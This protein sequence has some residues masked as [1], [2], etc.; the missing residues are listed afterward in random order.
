MSNRLFITPNKLHVL[1]VS[2]FRWL[3]HYAIRHPRQVLALAAVITLV[4]AP[5][6]L[7][8][9]LRTDGHA[10]V[11]PAAPEVIADKAVR[12][13]FGIHDQLVVL[14]RPGNTHGI[15][16]P[17]TLQLV[18]DLTAE[19]KQ[20]P[21]VAP[22]DVM[23][24]ATEPGFRMRPGTFL[25]QKMLE[26]PLKTQS[27][28]D[29]LREDLRRIELYNSTLVSADG[30]F[31]VILVGVPAAADRAQ[32]YAK[33]LQIITAKKTAADEIAVT[34]A[35][36]AESLFGVQI[37]EDLGVPKALLGAGAREAGEKSEWKMPSSLHE[38]RVF[39]ARHIGLVPLAA[40]VM[41]LVLLLCFRNV[42]AAL[43][44]LPGVVATMLLVFG[45]MGWLGVPIY[46]TTAVMPVL[47]TVIS[48]TNDIYLFSRYFNL[49]REKPGVNHV[50][51]VG[52]TFDK[53]TR[54]V[55]CTSLAAV[56]G[57]LSFGFSPLVPVRMFGLFTGMGALL[58]LLLSLTVVPAML[59]LT[60]PAWLRPRHRQGENTP[61]AWLA[62]KFAGAGQAVVRR[63][64]WVVGFALAV[65]ALTPLGLRQ[66]V[67]QDSWTNGFD[68][69]SEFRRVTQLVNENFFGMHLLFICAEAPRTIQ[70]EIA[71]ASF[72]GPDIA[73][74]AAL[75]GDA[76]LILGSPIK[77]SAGE[78]GGT[79]PAIWQSHIEIVN[80]SHDTVYARL[81]RTG[82]AT[83][84]P[85]ALAKAGRA[86][87]EIPVRSHFEPELI[88]ALGDFG[89]FIREH[90]QDAV[91]GVL[92]P[93]DY[94]ATT[95]FMIRPDDPN[96]RFLPDNAGEIGRLW[97]YYALALGPERLRQVV[98]SNYWQSLTTVF[99]KDANFVGT[100]RLMGDI[101]DYE[102]EHLAPKG[103]KLVFAGDVAVS[104]SL[105]RG[106]VTTQL[107]SLIWSLL[108]IF[109]VATALGGSA[110]WGFYCLLPSLLAVVIK[111][112]V[113]GWAD[114]PLGV[115]TSMFAAM[116]LGIGV[117]CT[118][119]L[120]EGFS[121]ARAGGKSTPDALSQ[122]LRLTGPPA[123][124]NT[125]AISLGFGVLMLSQV[126]ANARLGFLLVLGLVNCF[127]ASLLLLP[128]L[129]HWWPLKIT[130]EPKTGA[131]TN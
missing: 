17:A 79:N 104:Q 119:H 88:H 109:A 63:R 99:L 93:A 9:K 32:F 39:V 130:R 129:L 26:P 91:G 37:L 65:T 106:I 7:R 84:F 123:L 89:A 43:L 112:A 50:T 74:P 19:F 54:P 42:L 11:S 60:N 81:A 45:L 72:N 124:I 127:I 103:I 40:L 113:M 105:I 96:A 14:I 8:L 21:G 85:D 118:I 31:T 116:T 22:V 20:L 47:L 46:L 1:F 69:E 36:V 51:L 10:L 23:S 15:F 68:P 5:G 2:P 55:A 6:I 98:D 35:P 86:R 76:A 12:D 73:L 34:G 121:Q 131:S 95:R 41:M 44:P 111:F 24:L 13:H 97:D 94:L 29:Q 57:F 75:V 25:Q 28:L 80:R 48:V 110:R 16:N 128:V 78:P 115:A 90:R 67:V 101:R 117:N 107:Q 70:G 102:R 120:L 108:G 53:L 52:E 114:I 87:F 92:G 27:E 71:S 4:A 77:L 66:L 125:L 59:V 3:S 61:A 56:A 38:I 64:W 62:S 82:E 30:R 33:I 83:N 122:S 126:P 18:R 100:A 58:G 49:L